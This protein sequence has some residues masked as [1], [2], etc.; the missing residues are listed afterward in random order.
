MHLVL[1]SFLMMV[2]S[3]VIGCGCYGDN[4]EEGNL[5][6]RVKCGKVREFWACL[7]VRIY[8]A[9]VLRRT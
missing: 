3:L 5:V 2:L 8:L 7:F 6:T 9:Q 1:P 4:V